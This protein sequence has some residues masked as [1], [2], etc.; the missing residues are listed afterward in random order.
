MHH[1]R[2]RR[3]LIFSALAALVAVLALTLAQCT[4]VGDSLTG[5]NVKS[6]AATSCTGNCRT[7]YHN[8]LSAQRKIH[9]QNLG[10]CRDLPDPKPCLDAE[11]ARWDQVQA[12]LKAQYNTCVANCHKQGVGSGG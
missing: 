10:A 9:Q 12:D 8:A 2:L 6:L 5:V 1:A 3:L 11:N 7:A 4:P